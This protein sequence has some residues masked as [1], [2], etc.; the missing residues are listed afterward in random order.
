MTRNIFDQYQQPE[1][2]LTHALLCALT[3]DQK[4]LAGFLKRFAKGKKFDRRTLRVAEQSIPGAPE[5]TIDKDLEK[6]LPD[7]VIFENKEQEKEDGK[8]YSNRALIIE[9]KITSRLTNNQLER[10]TNVV[11]INGFDVVGGLA[12]TADPIR[13]RLPIG[14]SASTWSDIYHWLVAQPNSSIWSTE[15]AN[16]FE[17]LEE[18]M[19]SSEM[20]GDRTLTRFNGI[21]FSPKNPYTYQKAKR[22]IRLLRAKLQIKKEMKKL[23]IDADAPG[24]KA[25]KN[26]TSVWDYFLL[27][28]RP[29]NKNFTAYPHMTFAIGPQSATAT[30]TIPN[31]VRRDILKALRNVSAEAFQS[32]VKVFLATMARH[33]KKADNVRPMIIIVQRRYERQNSRAIHD[34]VLNVDLRTTLKPRH[35][36]KKRGMLAKKNK[37]R[38]RQPKY[39]PEWLQMAQ[40][41]IRGKA[42]NLQFQIGCEFDYEKCSAIHKADAEMLFARAWLLGRA[43][44]EEIHVRI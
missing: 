19:I 2:R 30:I 12:I 44:F 18:Q 20:L 16:F 10:H 31:A 26:Q 34:G 40:E 39:Q 37:K 11:R 17:V 3:H 38:S 5:T 43:F 33:F 41:L 4:L 28:G 13:A 15:L 25:I 27:T 8:R 35:K 32:A 29:K 7:G 14:W 36:N 6:S 21:P 42:S 9:S 24:A 23:K 22:L 1:N